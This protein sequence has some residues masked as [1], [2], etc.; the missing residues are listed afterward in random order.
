MV[1]PVAQAHRGLGTTLFSLLNPI[2][3]GFFVAGLIF[4]ILYLNTAEVMWGKSAAWLITFGLLIAIIPRLINLFAVWRRNGTAT[5]TDRVDFLLNLVAI[6]LAVWNAF[7]HSR[8]AYAVA[9]PG[10]VLSA[11]TVLL[12]ALG[13]ILLSL[14]PPVLQGGRHG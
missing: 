7:V 1:N 14:Q 8:D 3:F 4:D 2:P 11:L 13:F 6:V 12:I 10:T 5:G 9:V